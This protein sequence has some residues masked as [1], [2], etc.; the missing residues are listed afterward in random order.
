M[1]GSLAKALPV[2]ASKKFSAY[3]SATFKKAGKYE[4]TPAE[5]GEPVVL[6]SVAELSVS[7][8]KDGMQRF[9]LVGINR[10]AGQSSASV[11]GE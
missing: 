4:S 3:H 11:G 5:L 6:D 10:L 7:V 8:Q 2:K 9:N 1:K